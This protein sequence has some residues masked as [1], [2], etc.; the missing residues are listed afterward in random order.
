MNNGANNQIRERLLEAAEE[1]FCEKGFAGSSI[2][3]ITAAAGSN[4]ASVNY[5]FGGKEKLYV[6]VWR[7]HLLKMRDVRVSAIEQLISQSGGS[8]SLE[9]LLRT[10][11]YAFLGPLVDESKSR[12]L[13][14]LMAR[15]MLDQHL[16]ANMFVEEMI[17]PTMASMRQGLA[18]SCPQLEESKVPLVVFSVVGQLI[19]AVRVKTMFEESD[20]AEMPVLDLTE[21]VNHI[22]KFSAAGIRAYAEGAAE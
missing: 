18:G 8:P 6:E 4:I 16:P 3:D 2:R 19:H 1:L 9:D 13:L 12:Q 7:R 14:K 20:L 22:V 21:A 17:A 10:F 11:A 5:H 15:E